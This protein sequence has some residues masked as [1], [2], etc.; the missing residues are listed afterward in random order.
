MKRFVSLVAPALAALLALASCV[1]TPE[2]SKAPAAPV[3]R[4][5]Y[6]PKDVGEAELCAIRIHR[7]LAVSE[8]DG[9]KVPWFRAPAELAEQTARLA[10]GVRVFKVNY[11]DGER[12]TMPFT[13]I[14]NLAAGEAYAVGYEVTDGRVIVSMKADSDG[15][16]AVL[17]RAALAGEAPG[18]LPT[19]IKY[20]LNPTMEGSDRTVRLEADGFL[21]RFLPDL[22]FSLDEGSGTVV[23]RRGFVMDFA[24]KDGTVYLFVTE[25]EALSSKEFLDGSDYQAR[26]EYVFKPVAATAESVT[27]RFSKPERLAGRERT[28]RISVE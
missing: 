16:N 2:A 4:G 25:L 18:V 15:R 6:N 19:F 5:T 23:G 20:V 10:A 24:M 11:N 28:F 8:I 12:F 3:D 13:V 17:D 26:S 21:L 9:E 1:S 27:F 14:A 7:N 22:A